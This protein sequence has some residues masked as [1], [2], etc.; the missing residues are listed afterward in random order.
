M[1]QSAKSYVVNSHIYYG[2]ETGNFHVLDHLIVR[3][4]NKIDK[5]EIISSKSFDYLESK[6]SGQSTHFKLKLETPEDS[7]NLDWYL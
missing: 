5:A 3:N 7:N 4:P 2:A 6:D 1:N